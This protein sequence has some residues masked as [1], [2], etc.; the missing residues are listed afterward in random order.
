MQRVFGALQVGKNELR[1]KLKM[2]RETFPQYLTEAQ[3]EE[4]R[5]TVEGILPP[6]HYV[7][8]NGSSPVDVADVFFRKGI[9]RSMD[10]LCVHFCELCRHK[11]EGRAAKMQVLSVVE[12]AERYQYHPHGL[13]WASL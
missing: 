5:K 3:M 7:A 9:L 4:V 2:I 12:F 10:L 11:S 13:D 1:E 8:R 6:G